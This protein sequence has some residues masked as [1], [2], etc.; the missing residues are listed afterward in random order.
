[1]AR[2]AIQVV[3]LPHRA[4][5]R[6]VLPVLRR[7]FTS[8]LFASLTASPVLSAQ[9]PPSPPPSPDSVSLDSLLARLARAEAA[10]EL[11]R[12]QLAT[13]SEV[14]VRAR[15]RVHLELFAQ[16]LT[17]SFAT[18]GR[19]NNVDNPQT[20]LAPVVATSSPPTNDAIGISVRQ[21][22]FGA[23]ASVGDVAGGSFVADVDFDL[24]GG[25]QNGSGD[26]RL[27]PEPR[28]RSARARLIW[29]HTELL[30]GSETPLISDLNPLSLAAVGTPA[31]SGAGNLWNW[32][33]QVRVTRDVA[34]TG[35]LRWAVQGAVM[36]PTSS[37]LA[38]GEP[39]GVDAGERSR[40]P[41]LEARLRARWG[42]NDAEHGFR[43]ATGGELNGEIGVGIHRGWLATSSGMLVDSRAVSF[44]AHA[45]LGRGVELRAEAYTGQVLRGLGGG[46][47]AQNFGVAPEGSPAGALGPPLRDVAGWAQLNIQPN[48][49]LLAGIGCGMD[50]VNDDDNPSRVQNTVCGAHAS[51][52]PVAPIVIGA[53]YRQI[54]TRFTTGTYSAR[55]INFVFGFEL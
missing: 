9:S 29:A 14:A 38:P 7:W 12:E 36:A 54:G 49:V 28:L 31:F 10:I 21:S 35:P 1:M 17:N 19:V 5:H 44:D 42:S 25:V 33:G 55:H 23:A 47:I 30:I 18:L 2:R 40:R 52:R 39:D 37:Q 46:G 4:A 22:R 45:A 41:A 16:V 6:F 24:F 34:A 53:E 26:R 13:E 3:R 51:W 27:F 8:L 11:L 50:L 48:P 43:D 20:A 32:L 15:S